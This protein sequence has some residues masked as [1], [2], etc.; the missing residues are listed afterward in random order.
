[1]YELIKKQEEEAKRLEAIQKENQRKL[2]E[3]E[4]RQRL[5]EEEARKKG[6]EI[7]KLD[8]FIDKCGTFAKLCGITAGTCFLL[9][10]GGLA[11]TTICPIVGPF[12]ASSC[13]YMAGGGVIDLAGTGLVAAGAKITKEI[14]S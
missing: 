14:K 6:I 1:M 7:E 4:R 2:E 13:F 5:I 8:K 9:G 11:L 3:N 10:L 12:I